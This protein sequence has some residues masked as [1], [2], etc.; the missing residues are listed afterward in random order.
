MKKEKRWLCETRDP[1]PQVDEGPE[2]VSES[3]PDHAPMVPIMSRTESRSEIGPV[4]VRIH[5]L[6]HRQS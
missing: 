1:L 5:I 2:K 4:W 3:V 6:N